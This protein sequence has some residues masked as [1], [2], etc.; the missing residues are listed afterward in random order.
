MYYNIASVIAETT[1][2]GEVLKPAPYEY[3]K[4]I[5]MGKLNDT[6]Y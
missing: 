1:C 4:M 2:A 6:F 5:F 3:D